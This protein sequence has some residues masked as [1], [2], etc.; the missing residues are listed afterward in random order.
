MSIEPGP[1]L[2]RINTPADLKTLSQDE[3]KTLAVELRDYVLDVVSQN[4]GHL[5]ASLGVI[6]LTI[7]LHYVYNTPEDLLVWDVGHQAYPH[8]ILT[9]RR[10]RFPSNRKLNGLSGFPK[11]SESEYDTFGV[12]HSSTSI[13]AGIGMSTA[14]QLQNGQKKVVAIIGDG[15]LTGGMAFEGLNNGGFLQSDLLV[16]LNDN[17][18]GIDPN[19][20]ALQD[21]L[22]K[23][24]TSSAFN[25]LRDEVWE[26][27][28]KLN[29]LGEHLRSIASKLEDGFK[30]VFTPG[31]LFESF[32]FKYYGPIDGHD[33][34]KLVE[35][36]EDMKNIK[37]PKFLHILTVKGKG[38]APA[39]DDQLK[40]HGPTPF[41]KTSGTFPK[42]APA[43]ISFTDAFG[44]A[45]VQLAKE[46]PKIVG[47]TAAM[48]SGTGLK[49]LASELP[50]RFF[51][52]GIAEQHA[53]TFAAGLACEGMVP[54]TA[55]YS[56]FLQRGYDQVVHDVCIQKLP[57]IFCMDRG[58]LVG[59]D[60]P[61][62]HGVF[63]IAYLRCLPNMVI[64]APKDE[65]ELRDMLYTATRYKKGPIAMRYPR[66]NG[67]G[68]PMKPGF[69]EIEIG[70][71]EILKK[72]TDVAYLALGNMVQSAFEAQARLD[73]LNVSA[74]I[75]NMRFVKPLDEALLKDIF[76][77][78]SRIV[79]LEDHAAQGGFGSAV[80]EF[81]A[82]QRYKG[83]IEV[84]GIIDQ[85]IEHG[86]PAECF[87]M[88]G[89]D[90][91][92]IVKRTLQLTGSVVKA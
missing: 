4:G 15:A 23:V 40:F 76:S 67:L 68:V 54:I 58:G 48:P 85:F 83:E 84:I 29:H 6:E 56:T 59:S 78:H 28:G 9:G 87:T 34:P 75:V 63:D 5:G 82:Q 27:L 74:E 43:P 45:V 77:R 39:E 38:Y 60:G 64:M 25:K 57:V 41:D 70:K 88:A 30:A 17:R 14:N 19:T 81:A 33:L 79:T 50:D 72:G 16:V 44:K 61:T 89:I 90:T 13:S 49:H 36:L 69:D 18:M 37:G 71:G 46:N 73:E 20:G 12:G 53:V 32:G 92:S 80:L 10:D 62:H 1:L 91:D 47:I 42:K 65:S 52:V 11:R 35:T 66:G 7:A 2:A 51:D 21:Y 8:K 24:T 22:T 3:L 86:T 31:M 55:I 26:K